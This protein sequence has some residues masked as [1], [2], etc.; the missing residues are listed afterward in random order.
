MAGVR[1]AAQR[2]ALGRWGRASG[3][4]RA[5]PSGECGGARRA[6][7]CGLALTPRLTERG[8]C[9][10]NRMVRHVNR[11]RWPGRLDQRVAR[12]CERRLKRA[13]GDGG[14]SSRFPLSLVGSV[15]FRALKGSRVYCAGRRGVHY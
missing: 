9:C 13:G 12:S 14:L 1:S 2:R 8:S 15:K 6:R 3:C 10:T 5:S 7:W 4:A 11:G